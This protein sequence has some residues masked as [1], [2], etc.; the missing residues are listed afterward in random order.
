MVVTAWTFAS[1]ATG[2][3]SIVRVEHGIHAARGHHRER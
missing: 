2:Y 3:D 1:K